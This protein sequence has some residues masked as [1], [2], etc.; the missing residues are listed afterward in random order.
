MGIYWILK[1]TAS[2]K[3]QHGTS[4]FDADTRN[5]VRLNRNNPGFYPPE[6]HVYTT[7]PRPPPQP[8]DDGPP[9]YHWY[10]RY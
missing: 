3:I 5:F 4:I 1:T 10:G 9:S 7:P 2:E 6:H 8:E